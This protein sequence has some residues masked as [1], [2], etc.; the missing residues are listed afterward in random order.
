MTERVQ[1]VRVVFGGGS[2]KEYAFLTLEEL[3]VGDK[4]VVSCSTGYQVADVV[5]L[6]DPNGRAKSYVVQKVDVQGFKERQKRLQDKLALQ[7]EMKRRA[8][9]LKEKEYFKEL[10]EHD[11]VMSVL[12]KK[13]EELVK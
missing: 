8:E 12:F 5:G 6:G 13:Y 1:A 11:P 9:V 3:E 2:F 4:V 10:A 7:A